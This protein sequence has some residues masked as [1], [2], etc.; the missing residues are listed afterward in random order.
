MKRLNLLPIFNN[1]KMS[2]YKCVISKIILQ[3]Q[4]YKILKINF[5]N[6]RKNWELREQ[7]FNKNRNKLKF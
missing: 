5:H 6:L 1:K 4:K 7:K 2:Y 3:I